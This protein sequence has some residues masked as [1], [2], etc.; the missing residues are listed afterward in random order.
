MAPPIHSHFV[1]P[2]DVTYRITT[3]SGRTVVCTGD[4]PFLTSSGMVEAQNLDPALGFLQARLDVGFQ[5]LL[6]G[7]LGPRAL[8]LARP[9]ALEEHVGLLAGQLQLR[10]GLLQLEAGLV[11]FVVSRALSCIGVD[12][13]VLPRWGEGKE[14]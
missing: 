5:N 9:R 12:A 1:R 8:A 7:Q 14:E 11:D 13:G 6:F 10:L 4:H 3:Q 2:A